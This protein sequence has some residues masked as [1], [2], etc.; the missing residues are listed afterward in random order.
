MCTTEPP[1]ER[2]VLW[3]VVNGVDT[4]SD[5]L[6]DRAGVNSGKSQNVIVRNRGIA[7]IKKLASEWAI[8][9]LSNGNIRCR[10]HG[11]NTK[12]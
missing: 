7:M 2:V 12:F 5:E 10:R 9:M 11:K 3:D 8:A 6:C 1:C 4:E